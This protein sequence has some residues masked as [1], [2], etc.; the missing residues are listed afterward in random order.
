[1]NILTDSSTD[2][3][4]LSSTQLG[5]WLDQVLHPDLPLYNIGAF[6]PVD[7]PIDVECLKKAL[8]EVTSR[9][10]AMRLVLCSTADVAR[11]KVISALDV[12]LV[13]VDLSGE[14]DGE[15]KARQHIQETL[16]SRST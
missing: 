10:D 14:T 2:T 11:Q 5:I 16:S 6:V 1:M 12:P 4:P 3:F 9:N 15:T 8:H 7:S 13:V